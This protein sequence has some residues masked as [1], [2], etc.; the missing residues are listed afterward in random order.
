MTNKKPFDALGAQKDANSFIF[1]LALT[2]PW[3]VIGTI[4]L[5]IVDL[6]N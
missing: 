5:V 3:I 2:L 6:T 4:L 1:W